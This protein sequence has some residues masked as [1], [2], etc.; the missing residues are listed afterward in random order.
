MKLEDFRNRLIIFIGSD[1]TGKTS[2]AHL[3]NTYLN[4]NGVESIFT[5][6]PG[7]SAYGTFAPLMRSLCKD[8]RYNLHP[9]ANMFAFLLDRVEQTSKIIEPAIKEGK[10]VISDRW[11]YCTYAYQLKGKQML[12][13]Y[14]IDEHVADWL[15]SSASV[16][17]EPDLVFYFPEK[18]NVKRDDDPNDAF[19]AAPN[20]FMD[21]VHEGYEELA[22]RFNWIR[23][24]PGTSAEDTL[25]KILEA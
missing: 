9:L 21:R 25:N 1:Q 5:F 17:R 10:S 12:G 2:V 8:K 18:I 19:D 20:D 24:T 3:L 15:I 16:C 22:A 14:G 11:S 6:Q 7:D 4:D 23:V 13:S